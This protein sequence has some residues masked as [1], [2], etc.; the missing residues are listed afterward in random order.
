MSSTR[1]AKIRT[2]STDCINDKNKRT[3]DNHTAHR[4]AESHRHVGPTALYPR[5]DVLR[6]SS[7]RSAGRRVALDV[8]LRIFVEK[9]FKLKL[10]KLRLDGVKTVCSDLSPQYRPL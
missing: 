6:R 2:R 3:A 4:P 9:L 8:E 7:H 1:H 10:H 5:V